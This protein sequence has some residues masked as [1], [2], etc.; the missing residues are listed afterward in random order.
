MIAPHIRQNLVRADRFFSEHD[1]YSTNRPENRLL[2]AALRRVTAA[3]MA[4]A[5]QQLARELSF[6][7]EAIPQS[8]D[9]DGD[10]RSVNLD[11]GMGVYDMGLAWARLILNEFSPITGSGEHRAPSLL[12]PMAAVFEAFVAKHLGRQ[13]RRPMTLSTQPRAHHL[14]KHLGQDWFRLQPDLLIREGKIARL[15]LDTKWKLI[16]GT[17]T[18][19]A[20]KY[21]LSQGDLYQLYAYGRGYLDGRGDIVLIYPRSGGFDDPLPLFE[22]PSSKDL[23]LWVLPF[24]LAS[25]RLS[26]PPS[27]PF[28]GFLLDDS[29]AR[30]A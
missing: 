23:R 21:G 30:A 12:F 6:A 24:C 8:V 15:V 14:V 28:A 3:S 17:K 11:R 29:P 26:V 13:V 25:R 1:I 4:Q 27:A 18:K 7:F 9:V 20:D 16:D 10:F 19:A 22:F 2:H 5:N